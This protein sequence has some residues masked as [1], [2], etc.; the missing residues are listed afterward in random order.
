[1]VPLAAA[2]I[3]SAAAATAAAAAFPGDAHSMS[4]PFQATL[5]SHRAFFVTDTDR[6]PFCNNCGR[7]SFWGRQRKLNSKVGSFV[8]KH[9]DT[10]LL[11]QT[12]QIDHDLD[13]RALHTPL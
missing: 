4:L 12:D 1:M 5:V 11:G 9:V 3:A 8:Q 6:P 10:L 7:L 2:A 13:R